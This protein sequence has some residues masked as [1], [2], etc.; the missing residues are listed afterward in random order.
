[1]TRP[2]EPGPGPTLIA[3]A[4]GGVVGALARYGATGLWPA[5]SPWTT[6]LVNV[7]GCLAIGCLMAAVAEAGRGHPLL[8]PLL[9]TGVLGGFTTFSAHSADLVRLVSTGDVTTAAVYLA[10]TLLGALVAVAVGAR[11]T[12]RLLAARS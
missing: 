2:P 7:V 3:V 10:G 9:G 1:M 12:R 6:L 4:V 5:A 11:A 8:R